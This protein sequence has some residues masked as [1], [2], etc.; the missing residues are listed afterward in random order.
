[1][2]PRTGGHM[3][4]GITGYLSELAHRARN[5]R[6]ARARATCAAPRTALAAGAAPVAHPAAAAWP[7]RPRT[8]PPPGCARNTLHGVGPTHR[9]CAHTS[10]CAPRVRNGTRACSRRPSRARARRRHRAGCTS[11]PRHRSC[12]A[13]RISTH[14]PS[15]AP[16]T[17]AIVHEKW[18][19]N[20]GLTRAQ[21][22]RGRRGQGRVVVRVV[23][24]G[25]RERCARVPGAPAV[26]AHHARRV[27]A[28]APASASTAERLDRTVAPMPTRGALAMWESTC[29]PSEDGGGAGGGAGPSATS[30][31]RGRHLYA[32]AR[33]IHARCYQRAL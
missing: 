8:V 29:R 22:V 4:H 17:R 14:L 31:A 30:F 9:R 21:R 6:L 16:H 12:G 23:R 15:P 5:I 20:V 24:R 2:S 28:C 13:R 11:P 33:T 19:Q 27:R 25:T 18:V 3:C 32:P 7:A 10:R 1:M 26:R